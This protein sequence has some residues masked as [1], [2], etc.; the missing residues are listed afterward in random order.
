MVWTLRI[1]RTMNFRE[2][3]LQVL[4]NVGNGFVLLSFTFDSEL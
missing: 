2:N 3:I 1:P 4:T